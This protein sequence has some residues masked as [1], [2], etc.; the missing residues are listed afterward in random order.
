MY[1][2]KSVRDFLHNLEHASFRLWDFGTCANAS[3]QNR[4]FE[5]WDKLSF[6]K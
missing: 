1:K 3:I 2:L 4:V 5:M 6:N